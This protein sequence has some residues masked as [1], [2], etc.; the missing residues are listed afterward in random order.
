M[1][2]EQADLNAKE[3]T[4]AV[5]EIRRRVRAQNPNGAVLGNIQL[6]NLHPLLHARDA[7]EPKVASIGTVNPRPAGFLN[8]IIQTIKRQVAR[9]LNW[10]V[11]EQVEFNKAMLRCVQA[12]L[13]SLTESNRAM[14]ALAARI[15]VAADMTSHWNAWREQWEGRLNSNEIHFLRSVSELQASFHHRVTL[16]D[17]NYREQVKTQH[18]DFTNAMKNVILELQQQFRTDLEKTRLELD[19]LIHAE[20]RLARQRAA[21]GPRMQAVVDSVP[22][23]FAPVDWLKFADRFRGSE[24]S[25]KARQKIYIER[26]RACTNVLDLGCGRG[27]LLDVLTASGIH[28]HG[29]DSS[30]ECVAICREKGLQAEQSDIFKYL[31]G[32][33]D[34]GLDGV[35]CCQ[36]VEHLPLASLP[37]LV[38]LAH[39]KLKPGALIAIET[40]NPECLAIFATHFYIDPTHQRPIPPALLVFY[41][42]EAGFG[43]LQVEYLSPAIETLPS[44]GTLPKE[45]RD[46]FFG[47]MDYVVWGR[48]I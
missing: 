26:F 6:P 25:I 10:H 30:G 33:P 5:E 1:E 31:N 37:D 24:E 9:A 34:S 8:S 43:A 32:L 35:V 48:K 40:P 16:M 39:E 42:E 3:M 15:Q 21:I 2:Q 36:V 23:E 38:H 11:R 22:H 12:T 7:A 4:A 20:M 45:F 47:G 18:T 19:A 13:D 27:E 41:M 28:A 17:A 14:S 46:Q 44:V 29:V